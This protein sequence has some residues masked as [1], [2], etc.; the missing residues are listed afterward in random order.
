MTRF[1]TPIH[2]PQ[3]AA[4]LHGLD[5][6]SVMI[7]RSFERSSRLN[8]FIDQY[9]EADTL[10]FEAS[11]ETIHQYDQSRFSAIGDDG[12]LLH[13]R[14]HRQ[15]PGQSIDPSFGHLAVISHI[16]DP[17]PVTIQPASCED[18]VH[19]DGSRESIFTIGQLDDEGLQVVDAPMNEL[20]WGIEKVLAREWALTSLPTISVTG[21]GW[22]YRRS[23]R[24]WEKIHDIYQVRERV[25]IALSRGL[26]YAAMPILRTSPEDETGQFS[27]KV[28]A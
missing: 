27:Q 4:A 3:V 11:D 18:V 12:S 8:A 10:E 9:V 5:P 7:S 13:L 21:N 23:D 17:R 1:E 24:H 22:E 15:V 6:N 16:D 19:F 14:M 25:S 2:D 20:Q 28:L 26:G